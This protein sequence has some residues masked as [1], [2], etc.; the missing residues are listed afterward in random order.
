MLS[1]L[2]DSISWL[3]LATIC[4][5]GAI[6]PGPS[7]ALGISNTLAGGRTYG[8]ATSIGHAVGIGWWAILTAIGV[9]ELV[10]EQT[11][12]LSGLQLVGSLALGYIGVRTMLA[13][14]YL[15]NR[16]NKDR[17]KRSMV[18]L[19]GSYQGL[20]ISLFNPKI[21]VFFMAIFSHFAKAD[22]SWLETSLMGA[23]AAIID[24]SWYVF[25]A[26]MI[27][28]SS[29]IKI[30]EYKESIINRISGSLL[31]L[32]ALYLLID[33]LRVLLPLLT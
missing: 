3:Q 10:V 25:V 9:V 15:S 33:T 18:V 2:M 21:A 29:L 30:L 31:A 1:K 6:S 26:L 11:T 22:S 17:S 24:G 14:N 13:E 12:L 7:L 28:G 27:T 23:T 8:V 4:F 16:P 5:L 19:E 32:I 20:L